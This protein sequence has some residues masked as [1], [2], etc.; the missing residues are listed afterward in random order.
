MASFKNVINIQ[1]SNGFAYV[2]HELVMKYFLLGVL[3]P[4]ML[5]LI[6]LGIGFLITKNQGNTYGAGFSAIG[7]SYCFIS[8]EYPFSKYIYVRKDNVFVCAEI[9][10][11]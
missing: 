8:S 1:L 6:H 11:L 7:F 5:N 9:K 3:A 2:R 10:S 4:T